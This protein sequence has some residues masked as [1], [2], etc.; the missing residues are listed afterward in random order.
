MFKDAKQL[1]DKVVLVCADVPENI[2]VS[3]YAEKIGVDCFKGDE[4]NVLRRFKDC[5]NKFGMKTAARILIYWFM[6]DLDFIVDC[7][8]TLDS[9]GDDYVLLPR[10]FDVKFGADVFSYSFLEKSESFLASDSDLKELDR[11]LFCPWA[12]TEA[13]PEVFSFAD[14]PQVPVYGEEKFLEIRTIV[15]ATYPERAPVYEVSDYTFASSFVSKD[16]VR[17]ADIACGY[18]YGTAYLAT[19]YKDVV[20]VDYEEAL[21]ESNK[22]RHGAVAH[23]GFL[24]GDVSNPDLFEEGSLD[25]IFSMH[26]MEHFPDDELFLR[27]CARWLKPS[28]QMVLEVPLLLKYPFASAPAPLGAAHI[29]EYDRQGLLVLC[30]K[31]FK[32]E[33]EYGVARGLY[34]APEL[35][36]NAMMVVLRNSRKA[37]NATGENE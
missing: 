2:A 17:V 16:A 35:A 13:H 21:I 15:D 27:N 20:G 4:Q 33:G 3:E 9:S 37:T 34:I 12:L 26:S 25:A 11:Y 5:M 32:L 23:P 29:R 1:F 36:R 22:K 28:G 6:V 18:G 10:D 7:L 8:K 30:K 19:I 14:A 24:T 31:F